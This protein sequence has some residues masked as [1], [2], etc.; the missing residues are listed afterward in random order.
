M[1]IRSKNL[2]RELKTFVARG[3]SYAA[4]D[5]ET[6]DLVMATLLAVRMAMQV[7]RYD[8]ETYGDLKDSF[9]DHE[10]R[11]PMPVGFL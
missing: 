11:R 9:D 1:K 2:T 6:D 10:L 4:K 8:E 7:A 3:N 5:G